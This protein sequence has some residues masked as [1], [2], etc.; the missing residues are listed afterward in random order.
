MCTEVGGHGVMDRA[1]TASAINS[2]SVHHC[3]IQNYLNILRQ[4]NKYDFLVLNE[5][6]DCQTFEKIFSHDF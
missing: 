5:E 2:L 4:M 3:E 1:P 6:G